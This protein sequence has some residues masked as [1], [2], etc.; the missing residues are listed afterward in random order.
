VVQGFA[1]LEELYGK[2]WQKF[3]GNAGAVCCFAPGDDLTA[4]W[5]SD[6]VGERLAM[7][8]GYNLGQNPQ[9]GQSSG[10]SYGFQRVPAITPN[11]LRGLP[12]GRL[13]VFLAGLSS[14]VIADAPWWEDIPEWKQAAGG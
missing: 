8:P 7:L 10:V 9:G 6:N 13:L 11:Q 3:I 5:M 4:K 12:D 2:G 1:Q 14:V